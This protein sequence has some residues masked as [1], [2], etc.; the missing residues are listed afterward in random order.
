MPPLHDSVLRKR[1]AALGESTCV[2][3]RRGWLR[4][5]VSE[6]LSGPPA[7]HR[8][9]GHPR[10]RGCLRF[11]DDGVQHGLQGQH[12]EEAS[13]ARRANGVGAFCS[14]GD[15]S[16]NIV[17]MASRCQ[18]GEHVIAVEAPPA[19]STSS[20]GLEAGGEASRCPRC[21]R[22]RGRGSRGASPLRGATRS[23]P[24]RV[25][26]RRSRG[27]RADLEGAGGLGRGQARS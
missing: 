16:T 20:R 5:P 24:R 17:A 9:I 26:A 10:P 27:S 23:G 3:Q 1:R 11:L 19:R 21:A 4:P 25:A 15:L 22:S 6:E 18:R 14:V 12:G 7:P 8:G 13:D 2:S